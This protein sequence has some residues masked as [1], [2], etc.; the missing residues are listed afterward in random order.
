[1]PYM[2]EI[3]RFPGGMEIKKY[4]TWRLGGKKTRN[5]NE[6]ET[7]SAVQKGNARRAKEKLYRVILTNFQRDDW[8]LDLTYRDPPP[9]PKEAQSRIRKFL[10]NLKNLYRKFQEELKYI[11]VTEYKGHR[12]HH[13]LLINASMKIQRKDIREKWP[14]GEL[15]YRS[16]RYFDGTPEDCRRLAEYLC[17]ETD[18]TIREPGAVQKKRWNASRNLKRPKVTKHKIY[19]RHWKE[20]PS[21]QKG[22]RIEKVENGYTQEGYPYQYYRM[23]KEV[24]QKKKTVSKWCKGKPERGKHEN[25]KNNHGSRNRVHQ[26]SRRKSDKK[27][28][29]GKKR[30]L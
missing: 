7:E 18:E 20:N 3:F 21:P 4:H 5:Q 15:N 28:G 12:I 6:S 24:Q 19:S 10:R 9:D 11:Y 27:F 14:W 30:I 22:Y 29:S 13:H 16:F 17:K 25:Q 8:R 1:M 23:L 2:K 26:R